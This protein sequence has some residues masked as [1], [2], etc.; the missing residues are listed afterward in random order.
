M[1][2][3]P[4]LWG[5]VGMI[6]LWISVIIINRLVLKPYYYPSDMIIN[7]L[8]I[9]SDVWEEEVKRHTSNQEL[10]YAPYQE[11]MRPLLSCFYGTTAHI[12]DRTY[13]FQ[14]R[15]PEYNLAAFL[16][17]FKIECTNPD[18]HKTYIS[19]EI[20]QEKCDTCLEEYFLFLEN[21]DLIQETLISKSEVLRNEEI[22]KEQKVINATKAAVERMK[23]I[24]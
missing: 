21:I 12:N 22:E 1:D 20:Y 14:A 18:G 15:K 5:V 7:E 11:I 19:E 17:H 23:D 6:L 8:K 24:R 16:F 3:S 2:W 10:F 9:K 4:I 13:I